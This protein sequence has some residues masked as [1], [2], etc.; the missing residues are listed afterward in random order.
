LLTYR[1]TMFE[2]RIGSNT[3]TSHKDGDCMAEDRVNVNTP[4]P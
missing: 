4:L 1:N 2:R 3:S